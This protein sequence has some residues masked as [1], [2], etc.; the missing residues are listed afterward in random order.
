MRE[1]YDLIIVGG[2]LAGNSLALA[3]RHTGLH[4]ALIEALTPAQQANAAAGDRALALAT[5]TVSLLEHWGAWQAVADKAT[6]I[7]HIHV[8]DRGHFG[9]TRLSA[10]QHKVAAFGHVVVARDIEQH[11]RE[12][13]AQAGITQ[14]SP[15]RLMGV[16]SGKE[17]INVSLKHGQTSLNLSAKLLVG[18]DGGQSSV[19]QLLDIDQETVAYQQTALVTCV[20]TQRPNQNTAFE[21][22]TPSGPLALLP[23]GQR[24]SS[25]VW[26]RTSEEAEALLLGSEADFLQELQ[27]CFG[28]FLGQL[29][30]VAPRRAFALSRVRAKRMSSERAVIVGNAAHQL[31]P[32][33]GQGFNLG[34]RD[35]AVLADK[36]TEAVRDGRDIGSKALLSDYVAARNLDH[37]RVIHFTDGLVRLFSNDWLPLA[38]A[39][40]IGLLVFDHLP[41]A[42][43]HLVS[44]AMGLALLPTARQKTGPSRH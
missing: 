38:A 31:H 3:L 25:V 2:G 10:K 22:F 12:C 35:V 6:A 27:D 30:L 18:A 26:T 19:R 37:Q 5:G 8:S 17:A 34:L 41:F 9:K 20:K 44:R 32:V 24:L 13:V 23:V 33:A 21:R 4:I 42:K 36:L 16:M 15:G 29:D 14:I 43:E 11:L 28:Y 1:D 39:R 40:N 7:E